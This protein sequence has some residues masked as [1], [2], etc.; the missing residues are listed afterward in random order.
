M[1]QRYFSLNEYNIQNESNEYNNR[2]ERYYTRLLER[3]LM[4]NILL[5]NQNNSNILEQSL[6]EKRRYKNVL[7]E[8][9]KE[10]LKT[11]KYDSEVCINDTCA[12]TQEKFKVNDEI[13]VLPC[14]H[15]FKKEVL[16][17]LENEQ[18]ECPICRLKLASK[19]IKNRDVHDN[20]ENIETSRYNLLRSLNMLNRISGVNDRDINISFNHHP[21]GT[22][23]IFNTIPHSYIG[24]N[25]EEQMINEAIMNSLNDMSNN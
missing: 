24:N 8:K 6:Y 16:K 1:P 21:Y 22:N 13:I 23:Q 18:A 7:S 5:N 2:H 25:N 10:N 9:G 3:N 15:G 4:S 14:N 19:E 17:W 12:V 20:N 11:K